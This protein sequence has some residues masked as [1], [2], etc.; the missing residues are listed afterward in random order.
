MLGLSI[1]NALLP[2]VRL[3]SS[4]D[5]WACALPG[6]QRSRASFAGIAALIQW[7]CNVVQC[8]HALPFAATIRRQLFAST[9]D[10][11]ATGALADNGGF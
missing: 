2:W 1:G 3:N 10:G 9:C 7:G 6:R 4:V 11:C 8:I 5:Q